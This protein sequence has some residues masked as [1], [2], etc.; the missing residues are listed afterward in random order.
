MTLYAKTNQTEDAKK[1]ML[2][3]LMIKNYKS[4]YNNTI[5]LG[6]TNVFIGENGCGKTNIL[7][8]VSMAGASKALDLNAEGLYNRGARVA[9]PN[10]TFSSFT[11]LKQ[12]SRITLNL[13]FQIQDEK[14]VIP[15]LLYSEDNGLRVVRI[16][17]RS[18]AFTL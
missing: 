1:D 6:R 10:L 8:A 16:T 7:E 17:R 2:R 13:E 15:S 9:K 14:F 12:N 4:V 3:K 5:D 18:M 11:R